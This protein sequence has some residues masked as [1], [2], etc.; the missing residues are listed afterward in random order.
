MSLA[1]TDIAIIGMAGRFPGALGI[2][3]F[4]DNLSKGADSIARFSEEELLAEGVELRTLRDPSYVKAAGVLEGIDR[5]DASF[6]GYSPREAA[7]TDPQQRIF[8]ECAWEAL[9]QSG[10]A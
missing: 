8:L 3:E 6:F 9:E 2:G 5:F 4:W 1:L 10:Y 7:S